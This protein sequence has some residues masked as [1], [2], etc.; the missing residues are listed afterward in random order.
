M[1]HYKKV[2][3]SLSDDEG[4]LFGYLE[5]FHHADFCYRHLTNL[6][7]L[8]ITVDPN[9]RPSRREGVL[10]RY[11]SS[12]ADILEH[13]R[14][15]LAE[16]QD[17]LLQNPGNA[18]QDPQ[19]PRLLPGPQRRL[20]RGPPPNAPHDLHLSRRAKSTGARHRGGLKT[21]R[22][23][24]DVRV[25]NANAPPPNQ[26]QLLHEHG[27]RIRHARGLNSCNCIR[28]TKHLLGRAARRSC[29]LN[30]GEPNFRGRNR[31]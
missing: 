18:A 2:I 10:I 31:A 6:G 9:Y 26:R 19:I 24:E 29:R 15:G 12:V 17:I 14:S 11:R 28:H 8:P 20:L 22:Q 21:N 23:K 16:H 5:K 25:P 30:F 13:P 1:D 4:S 7:E 27:R 3:Q